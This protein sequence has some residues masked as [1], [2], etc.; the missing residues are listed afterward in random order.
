MY[1]DSKSTV[2]PLNIKEGD[3][4][5]LERKT[6]KTNSPYDPQPYTAEAIHGTQIVCRRGEERKMRDSQ[7]W[8]RVELIP[9]QQ[10]SKTGQEEREDSDIG[11][12]ATHRA[13]TEREQGQAE[14]GMDQVQEQAVGGEDQG[15]GRGGRERW[16][17][18][19]PR[20]WIERLSRPLTRSVTGRGTERGH[21]ASR[22]KADGRGAK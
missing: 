22:G 8:K 12:S 18:S 3:T 14:G 4:I 7:K 2:R 20:T 11:P 6:T 10:F 16:S 13:E 1:K 15:Q 5:L 17:F 9:V 21:S 19:P